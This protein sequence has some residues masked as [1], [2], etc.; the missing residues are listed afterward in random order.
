MLC[1]LC[2]PFRVIR[3]IFTS[4]YLSNSLSVTRPQTAPTTEMVAQA[5]AL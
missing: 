3:Q 4:L 1:I 5:R 2:V